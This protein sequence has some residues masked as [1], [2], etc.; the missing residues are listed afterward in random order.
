M[1]GTPISSRALTRA[2]VIALL[3]IAGLS[4]VS[5]VALEASLQNNEGSAAVINRSGRQRMFSQRIAVLA[6]Q[7]KAGDATAR[8]ELRVATGEFETAHDFLVL[9][10]QGRGMS[11]DSSRELQTLYFGTENSLDS[12]VRSFIAD[13][14]QVASLEPNDPRMGL[15]LSRI[16]AEARQPL[17]AALNTV[18]GI[19]QA[20]SE[21]RLARLEY[22]QWAIL[23]TVLVTLMVEASFI[24]RPMIKRIADYTHELIRIATTDSLT[25][26][27]NRR[28]F[29]EQ[30]EAECARARRY[31]R[32][33]GMLMI[34]VD[35]FK[36]INDTY[37]HAAGDAVLAEMGRVLH[38]VFR[39]GGIAG[40]LGGEEFGVLLVEAALP[41]AVEVAE[42]LRQYFAGMKVR[43]QDQTIRLTA[44]IGCTCIDKD[45]SGLDDGLRRADQLMYLAKQTGRNRVV[46]NTAMLALA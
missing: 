38:D 16:M 20:R 41:E 10:I 39:Q 17:L 35:H 34:D 23:M 2:Y 37:G 46:A 12:Q 22:L 43:W 19:E 15:P 7:W 40:R 18:V 8:A 24:F 45:M 26:L 5:H 36:M 21:A 30:C 4:I 13:A 14:R 9:A 25:G 28:S 29:L 1:L 31:G 44:S 11:D 42:R 33:A 6:S 32:P 3:I 27:A